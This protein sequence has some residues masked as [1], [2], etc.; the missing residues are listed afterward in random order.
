M[1]VYKLLE[2]M[3]PTPS[4]RETTGIYCNYNGWID[5]CYF[6]VWSCYTSFFY[7]LA[8]ESYKHLVDKSQASMKVGQGSSKSLLP[9]PKS[10]ATTPFFLQYV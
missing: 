7:I 2:K 1:L 9:K 8:E 3:A 5:M 6:I 10:T 4:E